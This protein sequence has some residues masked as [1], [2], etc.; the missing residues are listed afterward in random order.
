MGGEATKPD[1]SRASDWTTGPAK[2]GSAGFLGGASV[3]GL[4]WVLGAR[5]PAPLVQRSTGAVV[6][7]ADDTALDPPALIT[8]EPR[9][10]PADAEPSPATSVEPTVPDSHIESDPGTDP[11]PTPTPAPVDDTP[12]D[13]PES[14]LVDLTPSPAPAPAD[15]EP[16]PAQDEPLSVRIRVNV[17]SAAELEL[18]PGVGP[19]LAKRIAD[20][21]AA[22]GPYK[23]LRAL[24]RVK[25]IG[26]KTAEKL[27][28]HVRF[29]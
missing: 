2:W 17:A 27:A 28:P 14:R 8:D 9:S 18:L 19:V 3:V 29:D 15:P 1:Q 25:G 21:R 24:Q 11:Q 26:P 20:D 5:E 23:D 13:L 10:Q 4:V 7:N 12:E 6:V 16:E 22:N